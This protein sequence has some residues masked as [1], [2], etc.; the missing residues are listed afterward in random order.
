[1][2]LQDAIKMVK[3]AGYSVRKPAQKRKSSLTTV[4]PTFAAVW[5]DGENTVTRMSIHCADEALDVQRAARVSHAA[6]QSRFKG[7]R[8]CTVLDGH[9]ERDGEVLASYP[10]M[11]IGKYLN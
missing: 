6:Y 10:N 9:F 5:H 3:E 7:A 1:M 4:G 2:N 8:N 11:D